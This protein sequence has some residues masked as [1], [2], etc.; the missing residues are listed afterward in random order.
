MVSVGREERLH[1]KWFIGI[2]PHLSLWWV[3]D[4]GN[5]RSRHWAMRGDAR[6]IT[7][8]DFDRGK[9]SSQLSAKIQTITMTGFQRSTIVQ[10]FN[11]TCQ[12]QGLTWVKISFKTPPWSRAHGGSSHI[13]NPRPRA[14]RTTANERE[15]RRSCEQE[16][17]CIALSLGRISDGLCL[18]AWKSGSSGCPRC[19]VVPERG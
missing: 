15:L 6:L 11:A 8:K 4:V 13:D 19:T 7:K 9:I 12:I 5:H 18:E 3:C 10:H 1:D 2:L 16:T 17:M 14:V